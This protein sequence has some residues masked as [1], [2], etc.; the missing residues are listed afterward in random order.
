MSQ[1]D[2]LLAYLKRHGQINPLE[3]WQHIGVYRLAAR[4]HDLKCAGH[5]IT[6]ETVAVRNRFGEEC[7]VA[8]YRLEA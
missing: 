6:K 2:R 7:R 4:C 1:N 5:K 8:Q 3:A